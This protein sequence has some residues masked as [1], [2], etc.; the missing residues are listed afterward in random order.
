MR[1]RLQLRKAIYIKIQ[2]VL[3]AYIRKCGG[4]REE[5]TLA[6]DRGSMDLD[7]L[8]QKEAKK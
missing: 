8:F 1:F 2:N 7:S 4:C 5:H 3:T 6:S